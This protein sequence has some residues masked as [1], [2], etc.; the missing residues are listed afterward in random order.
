MPDGPASPAPPLPWLSATTAAAM[1]TAWHAQG[2]G[3]ARDVAL[4]RH[5]ALPLTLIEEA[6]ALFARRSGGVV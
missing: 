2:E 3:A 6:V 5:P 4:A 1:R